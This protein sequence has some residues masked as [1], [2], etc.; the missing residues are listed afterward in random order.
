MLTIKKLKPFWVVYNR[1]NQVLYKSLDKR[2]CSD[3]VSRW[4]GES[5]ELQ[6]VDNVLELI[7]SDSRKLA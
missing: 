4:N 7:L 3:F 6:E 5:L 1:S 2:N